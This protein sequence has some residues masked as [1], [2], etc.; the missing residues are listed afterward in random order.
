MENL[1]HDGADNPQN[2]ANE[3]PNAQPLSG[4]DQPPPEPVDETLR[5][6]PTDSSENA[7]DALNDFGAQKEARIKAAK[8]RLG[9]LIAQNEHNLWDIGDLL[10]ELHRDGVTLAELEYLG[11]SQSRLSQI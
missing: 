9:K 5:I 1:S 4:N 7:A 11:W 8:E 3:T 10:I 2:P 6:D